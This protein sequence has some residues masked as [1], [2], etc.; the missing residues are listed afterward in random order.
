METLEDIQRRLRENQYR[1]EEHV[2]LSLVARVLQAYGWNIW[3]P[4]EVN[5]EF[6]PVPEEDKKRVDVALFIPP[7]TPAVFIEVKPVGGITNLADTERQLRDYNRNITAPFCII[8]DGCQWKFYYS[9]TPGDFGSKCFKTLNLL[10][11]AID[12]IQRTLAL[13]L[14]KSQVQSTEARNQ[15]EILLNLNR[16]ERVLTDCLPEARRAVL[17]PPYP[18]LPDAMKALAEQR[19]IQVSRE[20]CAEVIEKIEKQPPT[21]PQSKQSEVGPI[22]STSPAGVIK[23]DPKQPPDLSHTAVTSAS[24]G[25]HSARNWNDSVGE[26]IRLA[27]EQGYTYADMRNWTMANICPGKQTKNGFR[28]IRGTDLSFQ[29][30]QASR[31]WE[32]ALQIAI[33]LRVPIAVDFVWRDKP[34]AAQP[35]KQARMQWS[36]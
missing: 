22:Q 10:N 12:D 24:F 4:R 11:D 23:C 2:R 30:V 33:K 28:P 7:S 15:A 21:V 8:T 27:C 25:T 19:G 9:L 3:D 20:L 14:D 29:Y 35:G 13:F 17:Q 31:A 34:K 6:V 18:N 16:T 26:G 36:P 5:T 1:N 32:V